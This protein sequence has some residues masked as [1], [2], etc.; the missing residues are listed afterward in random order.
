MR[1]FTTRST[2]GEECLGVGIDVVGVD[3]RDVLLVD[4]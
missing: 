2:L 1:R 3:V 4:D